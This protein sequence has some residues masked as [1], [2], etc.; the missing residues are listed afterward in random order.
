VSEWL[1]TNETIIRSAGQASYTT[2]SS[3]AIVVD[4]TWK[5]A[6][7]SPVRYR[8]DSTSDLTVPDTTAKDGQAVG[9]T[10]DLISVI[11]NVKGQTYQQPALT[12][13]QTITTQGKFTGPVS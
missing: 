13:A 8:D 7:T 1:K 12:L 6:F 3:W 4:V 2:V 9:T 10:G 11:I 5:S